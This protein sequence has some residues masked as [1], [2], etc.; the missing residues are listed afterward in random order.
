M[1]ADKAYTKAHPFSFKEKVKDYNQL[2]KFRLNLTVV[3][4]TFIGF[5]LGSDANIHWT[6]LLIVVVG[7][8]LTVGAA[9]GINQIIEK[10]SDALML[11]TENRPLASQ[12]MS[13]TEAVIACLIM[14]VTGVLLIGLYLNAFSAMLSLLSLVLY[15]FVY[16][17]LKKISPIAV[18]VGAIPGAIPPMIGFVAACNH[19]GP[20]AW[21]LFFI[22]FIWQFPHFYSIAWLL[23][24]DYKRAGIRL[25]PL[26]TV[27]GNGAA[28]QIIFFSLLLIPVSFLPYI[29]DTEKHLHTLIIGILLMICSAG[30]TYFS[31]RLFR[32]LSN[33]A[34]KKLMFYSIMYLPVIFLIMLIEKLI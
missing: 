25:L 34:A 2:I 30:F 9:N 24:D 4:S 31:I 16:T 13:V 19:I 23:D 6:G 10:D 18:Y 1:I 21:T 15:G 17:P 5:L 12:R 11:R 28:A 14:G 20:M 8:F 32:E 26:G 7:G 33:K 27:K 22:Q 3:M 29:L